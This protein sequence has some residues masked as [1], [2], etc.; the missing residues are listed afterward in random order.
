MEK[1]LEKTY[2]ELSNFINGVSIPQNIYVYAGINEG[3]NTVSVII[4]SI[5]GGKSGRKQLVSDNAMHLFMEE[6]QPQITKILSKTAKLVKKCKSGAT[7][8]FILQY[9][10]F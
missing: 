9:R 10:L 7:G 4:S 2:D 6:V 5:Y 8:E 3:E 1:K